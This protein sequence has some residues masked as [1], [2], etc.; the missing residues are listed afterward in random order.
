MNNNSVIKH[1]LRNLKARRDDLKHI[2]ICLYLSEQLDDEDYEYE[3]YKTLFG[4]IDHIIDLEV[5]IYNY[6]QNKRRARRKEN[7]MHIEKIS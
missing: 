1:M 6:L 2:A 5:D 3:T 4:F 7:G